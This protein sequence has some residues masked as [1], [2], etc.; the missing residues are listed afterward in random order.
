MW[1]KNLDDAEIRVA[2]FYDLCHKAGPRCSLGLTDDT[3]GQD[4]RSRV[5]AFTDR[6]N[7][8]TKYLT[9]ESIQDVGGKDTTAMGHIALDQQ[10]QMLHY[11]RLIENEIP[12][13]V[14]ACPAVRFLRPRTNI[15]RTFDSIQETVLATT[16]IPSINRPLHLV[17]RRSPSC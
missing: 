13:L 11:M 15:F 12:Q 2:Q 4:I 17:W 7:E 1:Q 9:E 16:A 6:L 14:G 10:R 3:N 5:D 8:A